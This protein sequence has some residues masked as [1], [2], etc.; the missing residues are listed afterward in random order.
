MEYYTTPAK[1]LRKA[2]RDLGKKGGSQTSEEKKESS[3]ENGKLGGR[4]P[5]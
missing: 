4:P 3:Q 5:K 1:R 2:A